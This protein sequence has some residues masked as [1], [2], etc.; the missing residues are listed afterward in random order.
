MQL[1]A[2]FPRLLRNLM[3]TCEGPPNGTWRKYCVQLKNR[4]LN[5]KDH[6]LI[7]PFTASFSLK[8]SCGGSSQ[9]IPLRPQVS[10]CGL[11]KQNTRKG[12]SWSLDVLIKHAV[13][14]NLSSQSLDIRKQKN[15]IVSFYV[16][17]LS[18]IL[19]YSILKYVPS[20]TH[21]KLK[22]LKIDHPNYK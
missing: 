16:H 8:K 10:N 22:V 14:L 5:G 12:E 21:F 17:D 15:K 6:A 11:M 2:T 1:E 13:L 9:N 18:Q 7:F 19:C 20:N 4:A 3:R